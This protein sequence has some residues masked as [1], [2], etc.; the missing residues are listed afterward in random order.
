MGMDDISISGP[1]TV[2]ELAGN[3]IIS[4]VIDASWLGIARAPITALHGGDAAANA[5]TL[6]GILSGEI[7]DAR[8]D[9]AI[10]NAAG[11]FVVADLA[12]NMNEGIMR[13]REQIESGRALAKLRDLQNFQPER[14][15]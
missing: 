6:Q 15:G 10:V 1:T 12:Q 13:A 11:G 4:G 7:T 5:V 9:L 8:R 3:K 14:S 2:A